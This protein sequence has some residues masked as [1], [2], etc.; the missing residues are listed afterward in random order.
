M[1]MAWVQIIEP[2][3]RLEPQQFD[4]DYYG[5]EREIYHRRIQR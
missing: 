1:V 2:E 3:M 5:R 4:E